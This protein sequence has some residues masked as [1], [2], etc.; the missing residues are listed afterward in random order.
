[1]ELHTILAIAIPVVGSMA[2]FSGYYFGKVDT[3]KQLENLYYNRTKELI[4]EHNN[5]YSLGRISVAE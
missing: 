4:E 5:A 2:F 1:M 3:E